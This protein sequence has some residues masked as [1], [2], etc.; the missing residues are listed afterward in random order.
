M[1][2]RLLSKAITVPLLQDHLQDNM[3]HLQA[4]TAATNKHLQARLRRPVLATF[5]DRRHPS[6]CLAPPMHFAKP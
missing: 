5:P 4:L 2:T 3:E 1:A 6:T